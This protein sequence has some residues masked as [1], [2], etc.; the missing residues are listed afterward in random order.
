MDALEDSEAAETGE[1]EGLRA[2]DDD[3]DSDDS[4]GKSS[5]RADDPGEPNE[6]DDSAEN[7]NSYRL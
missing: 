6:T 2:P 3:A 4:T 1:A 7:R 5:D